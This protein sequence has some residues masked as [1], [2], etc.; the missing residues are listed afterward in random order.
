MPPFQPKGDRSH[1][2]IIVDLA[3]RADLGALLTYQEMS[4]AL[5]LP[6]RAEDTRPVVRSAVTSARPALIRDHGRVLIA[7]RGEGYR[8]GKPG[9]LEGVAMGHRD[10][11]ERQLM[12]ALAVVTHGDTKSMS[13]AEYQRFQAA[14]LIIVGLHRRMTQIEDRMSRVE[15]A[16]FG[17]PP[18][19]ATGE[20]LESASEREARLDPTRDRASRADHV[21]DPRAQVWQR[22]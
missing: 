15:A 19:Q 21:L 6:W 1:R 18:P 12:K 11:S 14:K 9:E 8:V 4:Q 13:D 10:R 22:S 5:G 17:Q 2:S 20:V 7:Q 3:S 16:V